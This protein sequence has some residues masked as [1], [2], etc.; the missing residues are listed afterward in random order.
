[1]AVLFGA[2]EYA[3]VAFVTVS[4][5]YVPVLDTVAPA[6]VTDRIP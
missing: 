6:L 5:P 1:M 3:P 4:V 2:K